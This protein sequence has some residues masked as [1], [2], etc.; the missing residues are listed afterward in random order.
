MKRPDE[1]VFIWRIMFWFALTDPYQILTGETRFLLL[2]I[3]THHIWRVRFLMR[4]D[5]DGSESDSW[6]KMPLPEARNV[7]D[8]H[9]THCGYRDAPHALTS[10]LVSS[11]A[12]APSWRYFI[13][14]A[15]LAGNG[16]RIDGTAHTFVIT[17][18]QPAGHNCQRWI[19]SCLMQRNHP[20][21][22]R[23]I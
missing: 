12:T 13:P 18:N 20:I 4:Q 6:R 7:V 23:L 10:L 15:N 16:F 11:R 3:S 14:G 17:E 2:G 8:K 1:K 22:S 21:H 5:F 19:I 9:S